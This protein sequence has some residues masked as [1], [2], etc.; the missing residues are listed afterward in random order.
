MSL[1][2][3][4]GINA[5]Y[6][7]NT[8]LHPASEADQRAFVELMGTIADHYA[9][10]ELHEQRGFFALFSAN[11]HRA[12][13]IVNMPAPFYPPSRADF[14]LQVAKDIHPKSQRIY[15]AVAQVIH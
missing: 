1:C 4:T 10:K 11:L 2:G 15:T 12:L 5:F 9:P 13:Q 7:C 8:R 6:N 3:I 14:T